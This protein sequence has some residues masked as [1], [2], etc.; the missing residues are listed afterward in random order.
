MTVRGRMPWAGLQDPWQVHPDYQAP[1]AWAESSSADGHASAKKPS[2]DPPYP[3]YIG[4]TTGY[5]HY[6]YMP[7]G[8]FLYAYNYHSTGGYYVGSQPTGVSCDQIG[9][10]ATGVV[11]NL[12][13][14]NAKVKA[15]EAKIA[16]YN[17][18]VQNNGGSNLVQI[19]IKY[20]PILKNGQPTNIAAR[21]TVNY[22][23]PSLDGIEWD[24]AAVA[25]AQAN[26]QDPVQILYHELDHILNGLKDPDPNGTFLRR[27]PIPGDANFPANGMASITIG[28]SIFNYNLNDR[29]DGNTRPDQLLAYEHA[30]VHNDLVAAFPETG[31]RT[32]ALQSATQGISRTDTNGKAQATL[33]ANGAKAFAQTNKSSTAAASVAPTDWNYASAGACTTTASVK[34]SASS[35]VRSTHN[36]DEYFDGTTAQFVDY[37]DFSPGA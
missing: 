37:S 29:G 15:L 19:P 12:G 26:G 2:N 20:G 16:N 25:T 4:G 11:D 21:A 33:D 22:D 5:Y 36:A 27:V 18:A 9:P 3:Q 17:A 10:D 35:L 31:D 14:S 28:G 32:G 7:Y 6:V 13:Q 30:V 23:N 34:R 24:P 8:Q 1:S